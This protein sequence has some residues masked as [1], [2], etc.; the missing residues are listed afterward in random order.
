M[1]E[2]PRENKLLF[3]SNREVVGLLVINLALVGFLIAGAVRSYLADNSLTKR[4]GDIEKRLD[5]AGI[6][7]LHDGVP[8]RG[9]HGFYTEIPRP[10]HPGHNH[11]QVTPPQHQGPGSPSPSP[12][13]SP[14][15]TPHPGPGPTPAPTPDPTPPAPVLPPPPP[16]LAPTPPHGLGNTVQGL[17]NT[18]NGVGTTVQGVGD[19]VQQV[20]PTK[21][22]L[23][24]LP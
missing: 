15:P 20:D 4:T 11:P 19:T 2:E 6:P 3:I 10:K 17:G 22:G 1:T 5:Q 8:V 7:K 24:V 13:P 9:P 12:S 21:P 14:P 16:T 23:G 18:I